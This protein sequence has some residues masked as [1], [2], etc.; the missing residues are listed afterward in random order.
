MPDTDL[1]TSS[2]PTPFNIG[3][4]FSTPAKK[5]PPVQIVVACIVTIAAAIALFSFIHRPHSFASGSIDTLTT[6]E[7]PGQSS[8]MLAMNVSIHNNGSVPYVIHDIEATLDSGTNHFTDQPASAVDFDRYYQAFP[9][10][11]KV[12]L[13]PLIAETRVPPGDSVRGTLIFLFPVT[14]DVFAN[15]TSLKVIIQPYD[16]PMPLVLTK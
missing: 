8:V 1:P 9:D 10:L 4:E 7:V 3:E 6:V 14:P 2:Q 13:S 16:Q 11:K 12:P 5:L 15:K